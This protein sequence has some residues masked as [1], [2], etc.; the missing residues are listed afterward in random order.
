MELR[1]AALLVVACAFIGI[2]SAGPRRTLSHFNN[3]VGDDQLVN[4]LKDICSH[5]TDEVRDHVPAKFAE[6][7]HSLRSLPHESIVR[8]DRQVRDSGFCGS[9]KVIDIWDDALIMDASEGS[10]KLIAD[11]IIRKEVSPTRANYLFTMMA[12]S[13]KPTSE[14]VRAVLPILKE[15]DVPRQALLGISALI[16]NLDAQQPNQETR[17]AVRAIVKYM[18]KNIRHQDRVVVALKSLQNIRA[19][20]EALDKVISLATDQSQKSG[21]RVAAIDA[22]VG[23]AA[24][25]Q[26]RSKCMEMFQNTKESSEIRIAAYKILVESRERQVVQRILQTIR[27]EENK[28]GKSFLHQ[29]MTVI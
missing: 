7:A 13:R 24:D 22:L 20:G 5:V 23:Q 2:V 11:K 19:I 25:E 4:L 9:S 8:I 12:F 6:L 10:L 18:E 15:K 1:L 28:Q 27:R 21:V 16:R 26:V 14:A 3:N 29:T 17:E